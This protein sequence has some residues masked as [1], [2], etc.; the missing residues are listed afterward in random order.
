MTLSKHTLLRLCL[1]VLFIAAALKGMSEWERIIWLE[2][3]GPLDA[4]STI[5]FTLGRTLL[6]G[7]RLYVDYF[8]VQPPG[9]F[10]LTAASLFLTGDQR[11]ATSL[12]V[13]ILVALPIA[14]TLFAVR[15][16]RSASW[17]F[18]LLLVLLALTLG[19]FLTLYL[20]ER[21]P[22]VETQLFGGFFGAM[23]AMVMVWYPDRFD[24]KW[25]TL[26]GFLLLSSIGMKEPFLLTNAAAALLLTRNTRHFLYAFVCPLLISAIVGMLILLWMGILM[27]YIASLSTTFSFRSANTTDLFGPIV[28]RPFATSILHKNMS[29]LYA[30]SPLFAYLIWFLWS[31]VPAC[32]APATVQV[33]RWSA[34][35]ILAAAFGA[36]VLAMDAVY[37]LILAPYVLK[38]GL[39]LADPL[40]FRHAI[41]LGLFAIIVLVPSVFWLTQKRMLRWF[42]VSLI[43]LG[44]TS[45]GVG[46]AGY[47][48]NHFAFAVPAYTAVVLLFLR[49]NARHGKLSPVFI[50]GSILTMIVMLFFT[51]NPNHVSSLIHRQGYTFQAQKPRIERLDGLMA[52]CNMKQYYNEALLE[53]AMAK[54]SPLGPLLLNYDYMPMDHPLHIKTAENILYTAPLIVAAQDYDDPD[55]HPK[56][57]IVLMLLQQNIHSMFTK[58]VPA[59][60]AAF[61]PIEGVTLWFRKDLFTSP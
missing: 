2:A 56:N 11:L 36:A 23:F 51:M 54:H 30:T 19:I 5:Y 39:L 20:E 24:W 3:Q 33:Y 34:T 18:R 45:L 32:G 7:F 44:L 4:D 40:L 12:V 16:S 29:S 50:T 60:A 52:S 6:N 8:D 55:F 13:A 15:E 61:V 14:I 31:R 37:S 42:I 10:L 58:E 28:I 38:H 17:T 25:S 48:G 53:L 1:L 46:S 57:N 43:A 35:A 22:T 27:P 47:S 9:I 26:A 41:M 49:E 21:A 59:C